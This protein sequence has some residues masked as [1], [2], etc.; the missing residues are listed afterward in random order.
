M[1]NIMKAWAVAATPV[2][3]EIEDPKNLGVNKEP[4]HATAMA[5]PTL[6]EA[7]AGKRLS[8]GWARNL[9]GTW[10]FHWV[11]RPEQRPADFWRTEYD[12]SGWKELPV[13]S[14]W[15]VHGYGTPYYR[16]LGYTFK[17]D[18]PH[19]MSEPP[20]EFTAYEE[21]NP[22]GSYRRDFDVPIAWTGRRTML[23]FDGVDSAFFLWINGKQIGYSVNSKN[24]A[25]FDVTEF[26]KPGPGNVLALEIYRYCA[27]S[28]LED[29]DKYR[30]SGITRNVTLWTAPELHIR[31]FF[32]R[33]D[34]DREYRD[35]V[36]DATVWVR[37]RG[38]SPA[39]PRRL[40]LALY[41]PKGRPV[42]DA[43]AEAEVPALNP[44]EE[45]EVAV[46]IPV[47][48]PAKWTA[49]TPVLY[50]TVLTLSLDNK[51]DEYVSCRTGFRKVEIHGR[52]F[53]VNG[54]PVKLKGA[55][56]HEHWADTGHVISEERMIRDIEVLKQGNCNHVRTCHYS[57]DPRWYE[58]CD[59]MGLYLVAEANV[60]CHGLLGTLDRD[61]R[62]TDAIVDRN[63]TNTINFRNHASVVMWSLG[64]ENGGGESF[65]AALKAVREL[66]PTRPVHYQSWDIGEGN[67]ADVDSEMYTHP[68]RMEKIATDPKYTKPFYLCEYA[69]AMNNSMGSIGDYNDLFDKYENLMGGAIWEWQDQGLWN[70]RNPGR[71]YLAYGGG[72]GDVPNDAHFIHKGVVWHD[73]SP[74]P[75][76][77]EMKRAYQWIGFEPVDLASG[78]VRIRNRYAFIDLSRFS[79]SFEV[80]ADGKTVARGSLALPSLAPG[81]EAEV[82]IPALPRIRTPGVE[83]FLRISVG[84]KADASWAKKGHE[85][86]AA[87]FLLPAGSAAPGLRERGMPPV[88]LSSDANTISVAGRGFHV[89]FDR[90]AGTISQ[91]Y[92]GKRA[93]LPENG[94][95]RLHLWRAPHVYDDRWADEGWKRHGLRTLAWR[96]LHSRA[97]RLSSSAVRV[98]LNTHGEGKRGFGVNHAAVYTVYGDGTIAVDNT[99]SPHGKRIALG[100][101]GVRIQLDREF[102]RFS[103]LGRG[104]ME[105]YSDRKR[106]FDVGLYASSVADQLTPYPKPMEAGNHEDVRFGALVDRR[107]A[108]LVFAATGDPLQV[109]ALPYPDEVLEIPDYDTD[110]P[111]SKS[112][113]LVIA[114]GTLGVGSAS[115]GPRPLDRYIVHSDPTRFSFWIRLMPKV[116]KDLSPIARKSLPPRLLPPRVKF[117]EDPDSGPGA[118]FLDEGGRQMAGRLFSYSIAAPGTGSTLDGVLAFPEHAPQW[119]IVRASSFQPEYGSPENAVDGDQSTLWH[120]AWGDDAPKHPHEIVIDLG[121]EVEIRGIRYF[122]R[123][124]W[125]SN[126]RVADYEVYFSPRDGD[127]GA[128]A[129]K[130]R[131]ENRGGAQDAP[132]A[133]PRKGRFVR[134]VALSEVEGKPYASVA[135]IEVIR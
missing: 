34:L 134:F 22:V 93:L 42:P 43:A 96:T 73:R 9:N 5:Y 19:V 67:P 82:V 23:T 71:P 87:Q 109:S 122:G 81:K 131:F 114:G 61:P 54:V 76:Y 124:D 20:R 74:K 105:N 101:V 99:V 94:G 21:R 92:L 121:G 119:K 35:A 112:T 12:V 72:F 51:A 64:N 62:F 128:P 29:Q 102:D 16:N 100:R 125:N 110:L 103:Y 60:E 55:N 7:L 46:R 118:S 83:Y 95:P 53:K 89:I 28:Y 69:H 58:L 117:T 126:G 132:F 63:R 78:K 3:A 4:A 98:E 75:H 86:A 120:T 133:S 68:D 31:D 14:C 41:D 45:R 24:P 11:A 52:V 18:P 30:L 39:S 66:D 115:C 85:V 15:Q 70:R 107:G 25:E 59:E 8:S 84:L 130:G 111:P 106:G 113:V 97:V 47:A 37:N 26:V 77:P 88:E 13:P 10:K 79:A 91:L 6:K 90:V 49:E 33:T 129:A 1:D 123:S 65:H 50:T 80:T 48:N 56:R 57:D 38:K 36:L 135:E 104:P 108:G 17:V 44:G 2:P 27:G 116:P 32:V 127:W 40:V